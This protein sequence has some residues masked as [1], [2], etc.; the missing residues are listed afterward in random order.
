MKVHEAILNLRL[1]LKENGAREEDVDEVLV[2][3]PRTAYLAFA[4]DLP[5]DLLRYRAEQLTDGVRAVV[6]GVRV[7]T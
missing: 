6:Y 3:L 1:A 4:T 7:S 5:L 2:H